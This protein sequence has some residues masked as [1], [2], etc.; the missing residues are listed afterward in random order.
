MRW[1]ENREFAAEEF[2][3]RKGEFI[4]GGSLGILGVLVILYSSRLGLQRISDPGPGLYPFLL[5]ILLCILVIPVCAGSLKGGRSHG[6]TN[7]QELTQ[8]VKG[9]LTKLILP[10]LCFVGYFFFLE[11]LG[12]L[13]TSFLFLLALFW[14]GHPRQWMLVLLFPL[15][16]V[17]FSYFIFQ[18]LLQVPFP[19]GVWG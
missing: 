14:Y 6:R 5:G 13:I 8:A 4:A 19:S 12:F 1:R 18:V 15:I 10:I 3:M 11:M 17:I 2:R 16:I 9:N 7:P